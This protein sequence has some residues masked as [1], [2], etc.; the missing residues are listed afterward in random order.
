MWVYGQCV[1]RSLTL[2]NKTKHIEMLIQHLTGK[3]KCSLCASL[4]SIGAMLFGVCGDQ[5][6]DQQSLTQV[7]TASFLLLSKQNQGSGTEGRHYKMQTGKK[8]FE[9]D[10]KEILRLNSQFCKPGT[11]PWRPGSQ[12][13]SAACQRYHLTPPLCAACGR[14]IK[15]AAVR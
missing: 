3:H 12:W 8:G 9:H 10:E 6:R 11:S 13:T 7:Q 15:T 1:C 5:T 14:N 4:W 2:E